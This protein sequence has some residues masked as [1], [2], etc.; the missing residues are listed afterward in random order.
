[1]SSSSHSAAARPSD[2]PAVGHLVPISILLATCLALMFLT[3]VTYLVIFIDLGEL[4]IWIA[5]IIA[6]VKAALV[7][8]YF[9]HLRYDRPFNALVLVF[10]LVF[11]LL[12]LAFAMTDTWAYQKEL[13]PPTS[14][15][16]APAITRGK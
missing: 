16:Y 12:F 1:M 3:L 15:E 7:C 2:Q 9:M 14:K 10:S 8:M 13:V 5:L 11:M 4:N 6:T